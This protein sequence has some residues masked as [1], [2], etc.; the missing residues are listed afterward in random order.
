MSNCDKRSSIFLLDEAAHIQPFHDTIHCCLRIIDLG[1]L[2]IRYG[3]AMDDEVHVRVAFLCA[4]S[5]AR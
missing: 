2:I 5:L 4:S 3:A 1:R